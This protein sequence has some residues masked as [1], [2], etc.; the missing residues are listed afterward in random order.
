MYAFL[1]FT[2][3]TF[4]DREWGNGTE[5]E[6]V[7]HPTGLDCDQWC[8]VLAGAGF[9]GAVLTCKHH[10]GFCLWPSRYTRH[11]VKNSRW[12]DGQGDVV[13]EFV[14]AARKYGLK[15]GFYLSPWD[16]H[17]ERYGT[18]EP[19]NEYYRNQL[20]ELL[21]NYGG[22]DVFLTWFDGAKGE[23]EKSQEYD[24]EGCV[25]II[26]E[27][28]P[29]AVIMGHMGDF[30]DIR[31]CGNESGFA[32]NP[33]WATIDRYEDSRLQH[34]DPGGKFYWPSEV[35]VSIRPG[36]F[37]HESENDRVRSLED[38]ID[39]Y[40]HSVGRGSC[41]NLNLPPDRRG[42][43]HEN[44]VVR[45]KE[46]TAVLNRTF[47]TDFAAGMRAE[48]ADERGEAFRAANMLDGNPGTFWAPA[49]GTTN[50]EAVI[51][52]GVP[53]TVNVFRLREQT[54]LG[55][56]VAG[57]ELDF[58][59]GSRAW[60]LLAKDSTISFC[61][62]VRTETVTT[63]ALRLRITRALAAPCIR[64]FGAF[65][66]APLLFAPKI[67]RR[68][69]GLVT[70][71]AKEG[72]TIRYTV[73][74]SRPTEN[75]PLYTGPFFHPEAGTVRAISGLK[76]GLANEYEDLQ[77]APSESTL[78]FGT[79]RASWR[80]IDA[81]SEYDE[82]NRKEHIIADDG[83]WISARH[84]PYP[85]HFTLDTGREQP[86]NGFI[87]C[88]EWLNGAVEKYRIRIDGVTVM[89]GCFDNIFNHPIPQIVTFPAPVRGR[90]VQFEALAPANPDSC[91][92]S[93]SLLELF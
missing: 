83:M 67:T 23:G 40:Y 28:A 42:R 68:K 89:E 20:R 84:T 49:D 6:D 26:R 91:F 75:S 77:L 55:E 59:N 79:E 92:A 41:L 14:A 35:D 63:D 13:G 70:L 37:Y 57:F 5:P 51:E 38:L 86:I 73:D 45:L 53:R 80:V 8:R 85:H 64:E 39:I 15:I 10:D 44:D 61:K 72:L 88:V 56:R 32:G 47:R 48:S 22:D 25:K 65:Y 3:N 18:G 76:P 87:Y 46:W 1:H 52:L 60:E 21:E 30:R 9:K 16:R 19:Y 82:R 62:L 93:C 34:G 78:R 66:Q 54:E 81:D 69:D 50:C 31:W 36:W 12:R 43:L 90:I 7:F 2:V 4:T 27:C 17:D 71:A 58:R 33:N 74:G 24:F 11:S 29:N